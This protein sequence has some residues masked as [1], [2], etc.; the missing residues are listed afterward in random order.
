M[1]VHIPHVYMYQELGSAAGLPWG[2]HLG[3]AAAE[4]IVTR[5]QERYLL[6][7]VNHG[8]NQA[9]H[10]VGRPLTAQN[11]G[12]AASSSSTQQDLF[13]PGVVEGLAAEIRTLGGKPSRPQGDKSA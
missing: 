9:K 3:Q 10:D 5:R 11:T 1:L 6:Q 8:A 4:G 7:A 13:A 12:A 2:M